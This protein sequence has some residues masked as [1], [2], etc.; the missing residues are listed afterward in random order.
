MK[1]AVCV[2]CGSALLPDEL[3][4]NQRVRGAHI[5]TFFCMPCFAKHL[6]VPTKRLWET[7]AHLK[8]IGCTYFTRLT[9]EETNEAIDE[10][11]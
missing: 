1:I 8:A 11:L 5:G 7:A 4:L 6:G 2:C 9:E 3:A 10:H